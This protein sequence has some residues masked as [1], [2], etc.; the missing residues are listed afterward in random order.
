MARNPLACFA[1]VVAACLLIPVA[2][3][4]QKTAADLTD[5][6]SKLVNDGSLQQAIEL[7]ERAIQANGSYARAYHVLGFAYGRM[8]EHGSAAAAFVRAAEL[9][10]GWAEAHR[11]AAMAAANSGQLDVAWEQAIRAQQSGLDMSREIEVLTGMG[12]PPADL[13]ELLV[14]P[15]I[16]L[17]PLDLSAFEGFNENPFG[18]EARTGNS[19]VGAAT[20]QPASQGSPNLT[21][22][23]TPDPSDLSAWVT[24]TGA[25]MV[26]E[27][28][29]DLDLMTS[30]LARGLS[31]NMEISLVSD[32]DEA[33]YVLV[34]EVENM[35]RG[36][37]ALGGL[38]ASDEPRWLQGNIVIR[39]GD[40][41]REVLRRPLRLTNIAT[42]STLRGELSVY[43]RQLAVWARE[44]R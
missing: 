8:G 3:E 17:G 44:Q 16:F 25:P 35:A 30:E 40:G 22:T 34:V 42:A 36:T 27:S 43:L 23:Q 32:P 33:S 24:Q 15:R 14:A 29:A 7:A 10:P 11:M 20:G 12:P 13:D 28:R 5:E 31:E 18:R 19:S 2:A 9:R 37:S 21:S 6:A 38:T 41:D 39:T 1:A 26:A 4:A